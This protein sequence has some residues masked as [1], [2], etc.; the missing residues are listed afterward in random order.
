M[1]ESIRVTFNRKKSE[2]KK[3]MFWICF[4]N[5]NFSDE[6]R[7]QY[8]DLTTSEFKDVVVRNLNLVKTERERTSI[9]SVLNK[10]NLSKEELES[11]LKKLYGDKIVE[12]VE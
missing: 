9:T 10:Y 7:E 6:N 8:F 1:R 2:S 5:E 12:K 3:Q 4:T 11:T